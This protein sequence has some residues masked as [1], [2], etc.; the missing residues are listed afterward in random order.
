[1]LD[2][3]PQRTGTEDRVVAL[4]R[5]EDLRGRGELDAHVPVAQPLVDLGDHQV[6]DLDDLLLRQLRE[7]DRV[8]DA[9]EELRTEVRLELVVDLGLHPLV[10]GLGVGAR[11]EA[12]LD[13]LG[14]VPGAEVRGH[15][16]DGVLEVD[17]P[18][19][20]VGQPAVLEDLQQ[21]VE[22]VRV[23]LLDLVEQDHRE[24]TPPHLL[25]ELAALLV[26][27]VAGRGAEQPRD[28]VL[29]GELAHVELDQR[30]LVAEQELRERLGELGLTDARGAGEDER[31]T[32]TLR[33]LEAGPGAPDRL[34]QGLDRVVLADDP[35]VELVLHAQQA[36]RL[37]LGQLE[38]RD[39][40]RRGEDLGDEL[41]V[42]LGDD[43]HVAGLPLLLPLG[44]RR[45]ELLLGVAQGGGLLEVLRVDRG[46]LVP[47]R[48]RDLL[49]ELA[50]VRRGRH[51]A[52]A[53]A[54]ARLVDEVDRLVRQVP[55]VDVPVGQ[56]RGRDERRVR[57]GDPVVGLVPVAQ[58][59]EDLDRVRQRRLLDLDRLEAPLEGRVLLDVLAVLVERRRADRLELAAG[60]H[61]L[62]DARGVDR[63]LGGTRPDEGVDLVDEQDDVAAGADLLEDLLQALLEVTA[64]ARAGD[65][66]AE[67]ERVE[68]LVLEGLGDLA[69]HD[70]LR[71]PLDDGRL[72]D[73]GLAD[74][75]RVVLRAAGQHLHDPLD[76]LLTP[77]DRVELALAGLLREVATELVEHEG[78]GR[79]ALLL[80][81]GG[82]GL[83]ALVPGQQLDDLLP[84]AVEVG[85][86]LDED[87][88][89]DALA[90]ADEPEE[91]VLGADVVVAQLER[92]AQRELEDLLRARRE[93]DV[94]GRGLLA[95]PDDLLDLLAHG[96]QRDAE[97]LQGLGRDAFALVDQAE[98][99]VLGPDVVVVEHPGLLL[100][101]DDDTAGAVGEPLEHQ[102][103]SRA[104][105]RRADAR[106]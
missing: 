51:P 55:V 95:L 9:V 42:D 71:Q 66:R 67:V 8:V 88:G 83:L 43:V 7:D 62:E 14:D 94:P 25:R 32:G 48:L 92:L 68:L 47:P 52:D 19:L 1:M 73:A 99:D 21:R 4:R 101:Q 106:R 49:V 100:G 78:A 76:L 12:H 11:L 54:R 29:L 34:R 35:L 85:A 90:L 56:R 61:R 57:D 64:V 63:A 50:Q 38:D 86:E 41:L 74:Q 75:D 102:R 103:S 91:D 58:T 39:A 37:L 84:D 13:A 2:R 15:D 89:G 104:V 28:R 20:A 31:A 82:R 65:E 96:V 22:D 6:D 77:D 10:P 24:R 97:R 36:G 79:R 81:A 87:L 69:A 33:V 44:L 26:P 16:D 3:P 60:E 53:Q 98:Q 17:H 72:A 27:D 59:L 70:G 40:R 18:T 80:R 30:V 46:L 5:E 45:E 23:G 105:R 93:G